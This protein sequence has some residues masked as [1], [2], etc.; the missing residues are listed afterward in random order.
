[1]ARN[2]EVVNGIHLV[3]LQAYGEQCSMTVPKKLRVSAGIDPSNFVSVIALGPCLVIMQ[4]SDVT[5]EGIA[6]DVKKA[7]ERAVKA[8]EKSK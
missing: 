8:W 4:A 7:V 6:A 5:R 2:T 1:M 3:K